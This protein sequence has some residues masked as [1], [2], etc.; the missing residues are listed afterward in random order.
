MYKI[1]SLS[2][3]LVLFTSLGTTNIMAKD[4]TYIEVSTVEQLVSAIEEANN[5]GGYTTI[6]V[7]DGVYNID[8]MLHIYTEHITVV[9]QAK[10]FSKVTIKGRGM[11][12]NVS[13]VFLVSASDFKVEG[14]SLGEVKNHVIQVQG[15]KGA[16]N[17]SALNTR[18]YNGYEQLLKVSGKGENGLYSSN[19]L[20]SGCLFEYTK[21]IGPQYYIGGVDAHSAYDWIVENNVFKNIVSP[22]QR[23]A[24]HAIHFWSG[25]TRTIVKNN[26]ILNCDRGIGFGLGS[27][28]HVDGSIIN[29][30]VYTTRDVGIGLEN[31]SHVLVEGNTVYTKNYSNSIE[32]RFEGTSADIFSNVTNESISKRNGGEANL[33]NNV[34]KEIPFDI[35]KEFIV[36]VEEPIIED[37]PSTWASDEIEHLKEHT[38]IKQ[39]LYSDYKVNISRK[40]FAYLAVKLYEL[41]N[42]NVDL[43]TIE[44]NQATFTDTT[45]E[46]VLKA[47]ELGI[48]QGYGNGV[49]GPNDP[50]NREQ[51]ATMLIKAMRKANVDLS[52]TNVTD[53]SFSDQSNISSWALEPIRIAYKHK[54]M[55]G[56]GNAT[57]MP[58]DFT[59]REQALVL[60]FNILNPLYL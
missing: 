49:F 21:G 17:F 16:S 10:D 7:Q 14:L 23:L 12:G 24:E 15:E 42:K 48:I 59:T 13:H 22:E 34:I 32:Y 43:S 44:I 51:V 58:K 47:Y 41:L 52:T 30:K 39:S 19:G 54:I 6:I 46:Y 38:D 4:T 50:I 11:D 55:N 40:D 25:S 26:L 33:S 5:N 37:I 56:V 2:L 45:D 3:I 9:S 1:L 36:T 18:F 28:T 53:I 60:I 57:I 31:A 20:V 35:T 8:G 29:N 27:S